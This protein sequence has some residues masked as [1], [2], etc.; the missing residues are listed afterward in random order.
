MPPDEITLNINGQEVKTKAGTTILRAAQEAGIYIP[1]L[2]D[3]PDLAPTGHCNLCVVEVA[4]NGDRDGIPNVFLE[5]MAMGV[6]IV[7]T[8]V[9]A[10]PELIADQKTGLLVPAR[11]PEAMARAMS[12][13]LSDSDL[14]RRIIASARTYVAENFNNKILI[15]DLAGLFK[16]RGL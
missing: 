8:R 2:C 7:A 1:A 6:P 15:N 4:S 10:I 3:H 16:A 14:R 5:C 13:L 9:S 12:R 11:R